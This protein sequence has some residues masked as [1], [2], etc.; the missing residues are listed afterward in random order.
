MSPRVREASLSHGPI[1]F[2]DEGRGPTLL[3]IHGL[4]GNWQNWLAN[5]DGLV[6]HH[7]VIAPDLPGFGGSPADP[8]T[9][10]MTRYADTIVE[11]LDV[12][13]IDSPIFIGHSM[14]GLLSIE[15]AARHSDR[16]AAALLVSS[17]GIPL[18]TMRHQVVLRPGVLA[19]NTMLCLGPTRRV[20]STNRFVRRA[21]AGWLVHQPQRIKPTHLVEALAG[22][23]RRGF[24]TV[25]GRDFVTTPAVGHR[26]CVARR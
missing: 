4:G 9:V 17:G 16:V 3:L 20:A 22:V 10:T 8:G 2:V 13:G 14:G 21:I 19:L 6:H 12:L 7:R 18:T 15:V 1:R 11:L 25:L 24:G 23:G 5:L 26:I